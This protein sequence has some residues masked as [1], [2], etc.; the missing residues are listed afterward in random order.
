MRWLFLLLLTPLLLQA[1]DEQVNWSQPVKGLRARLFISPSRDPDFDYSYQVYLQFENVGVV[2]S[3]GTI[4]EDKSFQYTELGLTL[5]VTNINGQKLPIKVPR[6]ID[7]MSQS[8]RLSLPWGGTLAFPIGHI[9]GPG[10][11][12]LQITPFLAWDLPP[13]GSGTYYLS[14]IFSTEG[15]DAKTDFSSGPRQ[16]AI[17]SDLRRDW[18]GTFVLPP[19]EIPQK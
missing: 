4:R 1:A 8:W 19:V 12:H 2:G 7:Y 11:E 15:K 6:M 14:G 3:L 17:D 9:S 18:K 16:A 5:D 10:T 13:S